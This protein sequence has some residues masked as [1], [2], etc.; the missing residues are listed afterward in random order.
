M[1]LPNL[2]LHG[3]YGFSSC[4][5]A[6]L[7]LCLPWIPKRSGRSVPF[8]LLALY[9]SIYWECNETNS[10]SSKRLFYFMSRSAIISAKSSGIFSNLRVIFDTPPCRKDC[11]RQ[12]PFTDALTLESQMFMQ[13]VDP[14]LCHP[15]VVRSRLTNRPTG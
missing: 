8:L 3:V 11:V 5:M 1:N 2:F 7:H 14:P 6:W 10:L 9:C 4:G 13:D 12:S 15:L